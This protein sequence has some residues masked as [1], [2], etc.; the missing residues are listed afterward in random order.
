ME[1]NKDGYEPNSPLTFEEIQALARKHN[2]TSGKNTA[3]P[4]KQTR[5]NGAMS[6]GFAKENIK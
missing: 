4:K 1:L 6:Q 2:D 5:E 3:I